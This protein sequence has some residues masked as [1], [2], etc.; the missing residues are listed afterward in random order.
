[1]DRRRVMESHDEAQGAPGK[2]CEH[3]SKPERQAR[4]RTCEYDSESGRQG[5]RSTC[6]Y[7]SESGRQVLSEWQGAM[8]VRGL[9][10]GPA[11]PHEEVEADHLVARVLAQT[12]TRRRARQAAR[13]KE[14]RQEPS[15]GV[16]QLVAIA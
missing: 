6:E 16:R 12:I 7:D 4:T 8:S 14:P 10:A 2:P 11:I 15:E 13:N 5:P 3:G 1:M 9:R